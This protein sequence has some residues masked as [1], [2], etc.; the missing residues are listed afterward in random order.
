MLG[1][2]S[3]GDCGVP[4][5]LSDSLMQWNKYKNFPCGE[6]KQNFNFSKID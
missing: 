5:I 1:R 3:F 4:N 6:W 2:K